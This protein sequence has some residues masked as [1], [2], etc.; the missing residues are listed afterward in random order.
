MKLTFHGHACFEIEHYGKH[1]LIDPW[2]KGNPQAKTDYRNLQVDLILLTHGH[3][4][5]FG[6]TIEIAQKCKALI[7]APTELAYYCSRFN[8]ATHAMYF[9]GTFHFGFGSVKMVQALHG[10]SIMKNGTSEYMGNPCGYLLMLNDRII[11]HAGDTALFGDMK[12]LGETYKIDVALLPIGDNYTMGIE[13]AVK[14]VE[15]LKPKVVIPMHYNTFPTITQ[16]VD[17]FVNYIEKLHYCQGIR[18]NPGDNWEL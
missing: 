9:G 6:D 1:I 13:E 15:M 3:D 7:V 14:A 16:N 4:D 10:S 17:D 12:L 5:H 2:F 11:Y 18:L 8:L